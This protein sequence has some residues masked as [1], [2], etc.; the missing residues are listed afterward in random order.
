M[1][2]HDEYL[3]HDGDGGV[4]TWGNKLRDRYD[5]EVT[6]TDKYIG[7]LLEFI[8]ARSWAGRT[9]I[10][11]TAD[12]GE[13]LGEH[14]QYK[15]GFELY[16]PLVRV[17]MFFVLPG[18]PPRH[19]GEPRS[20]LDLAPTICELFGAAPD[21]GFEGKSLVAELYGKEP[22]P[23]DVPLDLPATSDNG[24]RR[25][26]L[27]ANKK[28]ISFLDQQLLVFDLGKDPDEK[29]PIRKGEDFDDMAA[30]YKEFAKGIKD[31]KPYACGDNC[32]N[33]AYRTKDSGAPKE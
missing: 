28:I 9:A 19:I 12:H 30:R 7:R 17:P 6:F 26:L 11:V 18:A 33:G 14:G 20:A 8:A 27:H 10:I 29:E 25:A 21:A 15:H 24:K 3:T 2:P 16:E 31:V 4:P 1:D 32:L 22:E 13:A 23:R 5:T